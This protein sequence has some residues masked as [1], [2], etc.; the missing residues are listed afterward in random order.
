LKVS[1]VIPS[2]DCA[3]YLPI[4]VKS[5]L[6]QTHKDLEVIIIDDGSKDYTWQYLDWIE[7]QDSRVKTI[8]NKVSVGRCQARNQGNALATG[9]Y[10][11][12]LDADDGATPNRVEVTLKKFKN[13][14]LVHGS[15]TGIDAVGTTLYQVRAEV[16]NRDKAVEERYNRICH[17]TVAYTKDFSNS[18]PY[19]TDP[20]IARLGIDDWEQQIRAAFFGAR[21]DM[22]PQ[23]IGIYRETSQG[24]SKRRNEKEVMAVKAKILDGLKVAA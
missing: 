9:D 1:F 23:L 15:F 8:R 21:F 22:T 18:F 13:A 24:I 5:A 2:K 17:S 11:F 16:F 10:I 3:H 6:D 14:D 7:K 20:E 4:A 12:V 19:S